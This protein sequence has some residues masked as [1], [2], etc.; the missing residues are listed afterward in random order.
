MFPQ[1][2]T[3]MLHLMQRGTPGIPNKGRSIWTRVNFDTTRTLQSAKSQAICR[4]QPRGG[5]QTKP[6]PPSGSE[7]R[8]PR[9][10]RHPRRQA[11]YRLVQSTDSGL[12]GAIFGSGLCSP[13]DITVI[14]PRPKFTAIRIW[15]IHF[16]CGIRP[17]GLCAPSGARPKRTRAPGLCSILNIFM[18]SIPV[19]PGRGWRHSTCCHAVTKLSNAY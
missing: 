11:N 14:R 17:T 12:P 9:K 18:Q 4:T 13:P 5:V 6:Q 3:A 7:T 8:H 2:R 15:S 19:C 10:M 16:H 1:P